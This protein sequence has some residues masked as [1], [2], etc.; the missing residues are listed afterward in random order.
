MN[1]NNILISIEGNIG[2][3]KTTLLSQLK[4]IYQNTPNILFLK[5]PVDEW[6]Q[7]QDNEGKTMLQKFYENQEKYSFPFQ[8]M[9]Y[10]SRLSILR[11]VM[12]R[13]KDCI[14]ITE[15]SL[16]TDKY[17]F[18][19]MLHDQGKIEDV[20][21][22]IYLRWFD[23]FAEDYPVHKIIYVE[24]DPTICHGR[25]NKR[26]RTGEECIPLSYLQ[27]CHSYHSSFL[28]EDVMTCEQKI[29]NGNVDIFE[30]KDIVNTW[31]KEIQAFIHNK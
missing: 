16:Y 7:I 20:N 17:V 6:A 23:E 5:E 12:Q 3:G 28:K 31:G 8:M 13:N 11:K 9:A 19:K 10:I 2:S 24:T 1:N 21:Y 14:I 27:E 4:E 30:N 29:I 26:S 22:Q 15:R 25:I 18:A